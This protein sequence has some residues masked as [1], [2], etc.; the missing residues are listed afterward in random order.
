M[1]VVLNEWRDNNPNNQV[2]FNIYQVFANRQRLAL[3]QF[4]EFHAMIRGKFLNVI[5]KR[6]TSLSKLRL[7]SQIEEFSMIVNEFKAIHGKLRTTLT[8]QELVANCIFLNDDSV[9]H[10]MIWFSRLAKIH[11]TYLQELTEAA[12]DNCLSVIDHICGIIGTENRRFTELV[13]LLVSEVPTF[14]V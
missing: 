7:G 8:F 5:V 14:A 2:M 4:P 6:L 11:R 1:L 13:N 10:T 12:I 3:A 9:I